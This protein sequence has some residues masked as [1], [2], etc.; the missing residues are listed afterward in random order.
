MKGLFRSKIAI[1]RTY[2]KRTFIVKVMVY[3]MCFTA[4]LA[5]LKKS[6]MKERVRISKQ[7]PCTVWNI[8]LQKQAF[9]TGGSMMLG[10]NKYAD[11]K[12]KKE[13]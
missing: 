9:V 6:D 4:L 10:M 11:L 13:K 7:Y 12:K 3:I 5:L 2:K 1:I 8:C